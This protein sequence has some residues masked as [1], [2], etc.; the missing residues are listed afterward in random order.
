VNLSIESKRSELLL[1]KSQISNKEALNSNKNMP[2]KIWDSPPPIERAPLSTPNQEP[3]EDEEGSFVPYSDRPTSY[4]SNGH[5]SSENNTAIQIEE[6]EPQQR[7]SECSDDYRDSNNNY[8]DE[9]GDLSYTNR[10][11]ANT[12]TKRRHYRSSLICAYIRH[13]FQNRMIRRACSLLFFLVVMLI[14][15]FCA[16]AIG[17]I[18]SQEGNPFVSYGNEENNGK[19]I[20]KFVPPSPNLHYICNDWVTNSGRQNCQRYCDNAKCCSLPETDGDSCWK[21]HAEDCATYR[22]ACLALELHTGVVKAGGGA[23]SEQDSSSGGVA[24]SLSPIVDLPSPPTNL[25]DICSTTSLS[26]P[27]GFNTCSEI[28]RPSRCCNPNLYD[29]RLREESSKS[30]CAEYE[31]PCSNVAETWRGNGH[32]DVGG[33]ESKSIAS[34]I[35]AKCNAAK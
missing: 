25:I 7:K 12:T 29:C 26:T 16:S 8:E 31:I 14:M 33:D 13:C 19:S 24:G 9:Y 27:E 20:P 17:Y 4:V 32:G 1:H 2:L 10:T 5:K 35:I 11:F 28:C 3:E 22:S 34:Q 30:Y 15:I 6:D 21:E 23:S 18:I